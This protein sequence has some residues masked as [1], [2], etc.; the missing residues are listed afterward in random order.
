MFELYQAEDCPYCEKVRTVL[1]ELG[2]SYV[3][4]NPRTATPG[5]TRNEQTQRELA[6]LGGKDQLPFVV[7]H[8]RG[9][10]LYESDEI[11]DHVEEHYAGVNA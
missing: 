3:I 4:H 8:A 1:T 5:D 10:R 2:A 9:V 11:I 6:D 7:D